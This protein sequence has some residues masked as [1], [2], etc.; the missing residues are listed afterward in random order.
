MNVVKGFSEILPE[1]LE[2]RRFCEEKI[3]KIFQSWGYQE[4]DTPTL[5]HFDCLVPGIGLELKKQ[6]FKFLDTD[7]E[8]IVLRPDMT[9]PIA[10]I[11]ATKLASRGKGIYKFYYL[12]NVF[13][14]ITNKTEEQQEFHQ[15]GIEL[16]GINNR[17]ADAEVIA[18]AIQALCSAGLNSFYL[19]IGSA[20]FFNSVMDQL[21]LES[22]E[23]RNLR[24]TIMNKDF[25]Q[26]EKLLFQYNLSL[27]QQ[28]T[29]LHLPHWRGDH[30]IITEAEK[31]FGVTNSTA[32]QALQEI[33]EVYNYLKIW[34]MDK[35]ILVDLGIIRNFDYY[36]GMVFEGYTNY[37]GS[38]ICGGGRYDFLCHKFGQDIPS[39]GV[40]IN[41]EKLMKVLTQEQKA[42]KERWDSKKYYIRYRRDLLG[43]AYKL[44]EKLRQ[45]NNTVE[46]E[47]LEECSTD[48]MFKYL[49]KKRIRYLLDINREDLTQVTQYDLL[50]KTEKKV[51]YEY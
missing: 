19:D 22:E 4:I 30:S 26:M 21:P 41:I 46:I 2:G 40:A 25:V 33:K 7:G 11:A 51:S 39:T 29:I 38:A 49:K 32:Q 50:M 37:S 13:R 9:T 18:V 1:E 6:L 14:R 27:E 10:R 16:L 20:K 3:R 35:F 36:S 48:E 31:I 34:G 42:N 45:D 43:L 24:N 8:V 44:A 47:L 28:K 23:K 15:A 5:E 12:N 17:L